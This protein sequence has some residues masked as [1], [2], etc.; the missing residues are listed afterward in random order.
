MAMALVLLIAAG[1]MT[2]SL[3]ALWSVNPGFDA[4]NLLTFSVSLPPSMKDASAAAIRAALRQ[5]QGKL[6]S[7]PGVQAAS[8]SWAAVPLG[9][10]MRTSFGSK[11]SQS[12][13]ARTI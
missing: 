1:L 5:V 11:V 7:T 8:L 12:R 6:E 9:M 10:T 13:P 4:R 3:N 2:R